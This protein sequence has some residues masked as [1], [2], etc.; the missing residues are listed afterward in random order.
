VNTVGREGLEL[1]A[2]EPGLLLVALVALSAA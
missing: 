1:K 2:E